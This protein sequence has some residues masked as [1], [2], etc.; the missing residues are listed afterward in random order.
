MKLRKKT[1]ARFEEHLDVRSF[2]SVHTNLALLLS[3]LMSNEQLLLFQ[4]HR[5]HSI[6]WKKSKD[7]KGTSKSESLKKDIIKRAIGNF[8]G[9]PELRLGSKSGR[10][11]SEGFK[12]LLGYSAHSK[13]DRK[14]LAGIFD[15]DMVKT[16][17]DG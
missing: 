9:L 14:L 13:L 8:E 15:K 3:M 4:N 1:A 2:V 6:L 7:Y 12:H 11:L 10:E 17:S 16:R 5:A